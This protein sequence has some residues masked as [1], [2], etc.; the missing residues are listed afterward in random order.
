MQTP[1]NSPL[2]TALLLPWKCFDGFFDELDDKFDETD[3]LG[4]FFMVVLQH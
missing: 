2:S 4:N 1:S 3:R